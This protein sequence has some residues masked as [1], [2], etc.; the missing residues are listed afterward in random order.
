M[1]LYSSEF[2][3]FLAAALVLYYTLLRKWQWQVL[4]AAGLVFYLASGPRNLFFIATTALTTWGGGRWICHYTNI[5]K[6][7]KS[8][9][10]DRAER[11]ALKARLNRK[12][13]AVLWAI[14]LLNF[15]ILALLKY[16][17]PWSKSLLI[18]MGIS[19]YTFISIGYLID[20]YYEKY[21]AETNFFKYLL[22]VS[23][24]PQLIQGPINRF[25]RMAQQWK[26]EHHLHMEQAKRALLL[27]GFG[28]MKKYV[29]ANPLA[30][31][32]AKVLDQP[33]SNTP[34]SMIVFAILLYSVQ[35]YCDFSGGID[36]V[37]GVSELF[38]IRMMPNFRQPYF[39]TSLG[40][41]WRR[42]HISLGAWMRDYVF[43]PFALTKPMQ[44]LGKWAKKRMGKHFGKVLPAAIANILVF[45]LVGIWHGNQWHYIFWGLYNGI[46]IALGDLFEPLFVMIWAKL[47]IN[48]QSKGFHVFRIVKTFV[49]V[50]IGWY[51]DR[52]TDM[53]DCFLCMKNTIMKFQAGKFADSLNTLMK[54]FHWEAMALAAAAFLIVILVS[55]CRE[56]NIDVVE[57]MN[58]IP[59]ALRWGIYYAMIGMILIS[60]VFSTNTGGFMYANF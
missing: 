41:F 20:L 4:L 27:I 56:K 23:Y 43:Y 6:I 12:K 32:I 40:D 60:F 36:M 34:G 19:F 48:T 22:F 14:L 5:F 9:I 18:P 2:I 59:G 44:E 54:S 30:D 17:N 46:V 38:G 29:I 52:I 25:D 11:K 8:A 31:V 16:W 50:N 28:A 39:A 55:V 24:F 13:C 35:Q 7:K 3:I 49:I 58:R 26:Q 47:H 57:R 15:G 33:N 1:N 53:E 42:W 51:F 21:E 45:F 10:K 37:L